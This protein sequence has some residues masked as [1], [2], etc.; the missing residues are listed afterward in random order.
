[1]TYFLTTPKEGAQYVLRSVPTGRG[2]EKAIMRNGE[3]TA[4]Q[5]GNPA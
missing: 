2:R 4:M 3:I 5:F 1:M